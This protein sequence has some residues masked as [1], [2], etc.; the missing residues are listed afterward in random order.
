MPRAAGIFLVVFFAL[1]ASCV[2]GPGTTADRSGQHLATS[3]VAGEKELKRDMNTPFGRGE[4]FYSKMEY[5]EAAREFKEAVQR[6]RSDWYVF[7]RLGW[8]YHNLHQNNLA[9][10]YFTKSLRKKKVLGSYVGLI[11]SLLRNNEDDSALAIFEKFKRNIPDSGTK[12]YFLAVLYASFGDYKNAYTAWKR[13]PL[14]GFEYDTKTNILLSVYSGSAADLGGLRACDIVL[15]FNGVTLRGK[16]GGTL[17]NLVK[18]K[19]YGSTIT[20]TV[21]RDGVVYKGEFFNGMARNLP[22]RAARLKKLAPV[23]P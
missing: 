5:E 12:K 18:A 23:Q 21:Q 4:E 8:C 15:K 3:G 10:K 19:P 11:L 6:G 7:N 17:A 1:L 13:K 16:R 22:E 14:V 20:L 2:G 9:I